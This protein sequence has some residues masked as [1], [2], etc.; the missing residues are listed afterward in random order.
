LM[1]FEVYCPGE[2][3]EGQKV[4]CTAV[5]VYSNDP[6]TTVDLTTST[7]WQV[8]GAPGWSGGSEFGTKGAGTIMVTATRGSMQA[9]RTI[10]VK[11]AKTGM[12]GGTKPQSTGTGKPAGGGGCGPGTSCKCAGGAIGH[13]SCDT[14]KCHCG[15]G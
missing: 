13:I 7:G 2:V 8:T 11:S 10:H 1:G 6:Y 9:T 4:R 5:G 12:D 15:G 14:G 3:A